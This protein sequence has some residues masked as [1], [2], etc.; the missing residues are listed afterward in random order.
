MI[1]YDPPY[2][3]G[4][5][6]PFCFCC[7]AA[8]YEKLWNAAGGAENKGMHHLLPDRFCYDDRSYVG[9]DVFFCDLSNPCLHDE[10]F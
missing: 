9:G 7:G 4:T 1:I 2:S 5:C 8:F 6:P 10:L 3:G